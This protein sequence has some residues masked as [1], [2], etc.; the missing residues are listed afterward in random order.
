MAEIKRMC[1]I[2]GKVADYTCKVCGR[3]YCKD[4]I[5][6]KSMMCGSCRRGR[7]L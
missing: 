7:T 4:H 1:T 5:D 6:Q 2:C 3:P